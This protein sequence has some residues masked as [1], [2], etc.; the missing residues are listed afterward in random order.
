M[1]RYTNLIDVLENIGEEIVQQYK[2]ELQQH[3][4]IASGKLFNSIDYRIEVTNEGV[5][6]YFVAEDYYI[7]VEKG[8]NPGGKFPPIDVIKKWMISRS[9]P[10]KPGLA[11]IIARRI[12]EKGIKGISE[13]T[14]IRTDVSKYNDLL[15]EALTKDLLNYGDNNIKQFSITR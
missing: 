15:T 11:Y 8:R 10:D 7:N 3:N 9:I 6:L 2:D 13:L 12:A 1:T 4:K 14:T 5:T